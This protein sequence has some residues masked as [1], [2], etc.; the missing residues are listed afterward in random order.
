MKYGLLLFG[1]GLMIASC[2]TVE[3]KPPRP[4]V[5][6]P[7]VIVTNTV[8]VVV[9]NEVYGF[10]DLNS[11]T[12]I[13]KVF[14][15]PLRHNTNGGSVVEL[16]FYEFAGTNIVGSTNLTFNLSTNSPILFIDAAVAPID[17]P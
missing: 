7:P 10:V 17:Q 14:S 3:S 15:F 1:L 5:V 9:T 2:V 11:R 6:K 16:E 12:N 4:P 8:T 13:A